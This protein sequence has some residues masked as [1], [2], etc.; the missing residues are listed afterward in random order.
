LASLA[1]QD[2]GE[3]V[4]DVEAILGGDSSAVEAGNAPELTQGGPESPTRAMPRMTAVTSWG[5]LLAWDPINL[6]GDYVWQQ[7]RRVE[8]GKFS[9]FR[10]AMAP[11]G[12]RRLHAQP[13]TR[14]PRPSEACRRTP[15]L[16]P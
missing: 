1:R 16:H 12:R 5:E 11:H 10:E 7:T 3:I 13:R 15:M 6:T 9:P 8:K 14:P 4:L 2:A